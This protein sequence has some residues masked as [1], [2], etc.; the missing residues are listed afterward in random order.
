MSLR[1]KAG[2]LRLFGTIVKDEYIWPEDTGFFSAQMVLDALAETPG[3][4][5][6]YVNSDGGMP[7]EGEAIRAALEAHPGRV[8]VKVTGNAHS[9]ASLMIMSADHI[10]M[11][12]GSL[13]LIHDPSVYASGNAAEL[14]A[15]AAEL[16][17]M[18][19][20]YATVYAARAGI[21]LEE[22][23]AIMKAETMLG[24][25]AAV[26]AGFADAVTRLPEMQKAQSPGDRTAALAAIT[27]AM[28]RAREA[29]MKFEA[30]DDPRL[31]AGE[32]QTT[33]QE[34]NE[35]N[36]DPMPNKNVTPPVVATPV[37]AAAPVQTPAPAAVP[38]PV[39]EPVMQADAVAADRLRIKTIRMNAKPF[40]AHISE[41]EI[42]RMCDEGTSVAEA[43]QVIMNAA[44][45]A[46]PRTT[47]VDILRDETDTKVEGMIGALMHRANPRMHALEGPAEA[48][49]G[50]R[51]KSLAMHLAA[52]G[53]GF[54]DIETVRAGL[55]G[56]SLMSGALGVSDFAY[57]TTEVMN[58]TLR[59]AYEHRAATWQMISR[60][61]TA[62]DFREL[63]SIAAG[64]DFQLKPVGENGEYLQSSITDEGQGLRLAKYGRN[65]NL[66]F[67][68]IIND[69]MG[70]FE[71]LPG[72]FA[73]A[74]GVLESKIAWGAIRDNAKVGDGIALFHADHKNLGAAGAIAVTTVGD[75]RAA[76]YHQ[77]PAGS[78]DADDFIS[79]T[80]DLLFV[81]PALETVA[82]QFVAQSTPT[83]MADTNP[84]NGTMR[85]VVEASLSA[86]AGGS[87]SRWYLF[88]S[89]MPVLEHAFLDGYE[90]PTVMT[91]EGMNPDGV[92]MVARHI[93]AATP[94]E[95]RGAYRRG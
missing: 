17:V 54:N 15:A 77:R 2:E 56:T 18:A 26:E 79:V 73:R 41:A 66:T 60:M 91:K 21:S 14:T 29:Q 94:V 42:D 88:A 87:D 63:H 16:D 72:D 8:T 32:S 84:F 27:V 74:A 80:P 37:V 70:V 64:G 44:A 34:A 92:N 13:M 45:A 7:S 49:K 3:D 28:S 83:K 68:A 9:A 58:R 25:E 67:E 1:L 93:F 40:S 85:P 81:P 6:L 76:M 55:R 78:K 35:T 82:G 43:N 23:R 62:T 47:R 38:A 57:I 5:T 75:G 24:A 39:A 50:L 86:A 95:F 61:R 71:R 48:F 11:S 52:G 51:V 19:D 90:A 65:I 89:D 12:A 33:G 36:G 69:D 31:E 22:A 10:E 30:A 4:V 59:A 46:Q 20:A 53:R